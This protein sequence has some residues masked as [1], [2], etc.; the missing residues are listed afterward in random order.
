[1]GLAILF[2]AV[3]FYIGMSIWE[4]NQR[5]KVTYRNGEERHSYKSLARLMEEEELEF[6]FPARIPETVRVEEVW[7]SE[8]DNS[9][10][11]QFSP[12][13]SGYSM[14]VRK[15]AEPRQP[16]EGAENILCSGI[17]FELKVI[18]KK[19]RPSVYWAGGWY[20]GYFY[21]LQAP[22]REGLLMMLNSLK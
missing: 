5:N 15:E 13:S 1:M 22:N 3:S 17:M 6:L 10:H 12:I 4:H 21:I 2:L 7:E 14:T 11:I 16:E 18:E 19:E 9:F 8:A 20:N